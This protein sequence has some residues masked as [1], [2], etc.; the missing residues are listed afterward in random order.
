[1]YVFVQSI[2]YPVFFSAIPLNQAQA[3]LVVLAESFRRSGM[4]SAASDFAVMNT[5]GGVGKSTLVLAMSET[6]SVKRRRYRCPFNQVATITTPDTN[7]IS[8]QV[9]RTCEPAVSRSP[10]GGGVDVRNDGYVPRP[11]FWRGVVR[12]VDVSNDRRTA[13]SVPDIE[14]HEIPGS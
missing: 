10:L 3:V 13:E 7:T 9:D 6:L 2:D 4:P 1:V 11:L 14:A 12:R 5:K 8:V